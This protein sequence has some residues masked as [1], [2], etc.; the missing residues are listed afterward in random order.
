MHH[1]QDEDGIG[2]N[3]VVDDM[4]LGKPGADSWSE[5]FPGASDF[6]IA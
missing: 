4:T 5:I 6:G 3:L 1:T 2:K